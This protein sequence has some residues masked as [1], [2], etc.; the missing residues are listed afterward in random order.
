MNRGKQKDILTRLYKI[1]QLRET[2]A[3]A[4]LGRA[5]SLTQQA[6]IKAR[7]KSALRLTHVAEAATTEEQILARMTGKVIDLASLQYLEAFQ[8]RTTEV[9][10]Q[11]QEEET[12]A[13]LLL[14]QSK[15]KLGLEQNEYEIIHVSTT[16]L[17]ELINKLNKSGVD[18]DEWPV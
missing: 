9:A 1:R 13:K 16:K 8:Q 5:R 2:K 3:E 10:E 4:S 14:D 12:A 18:I 15:E 17:E 7:E 11:Q 6:G